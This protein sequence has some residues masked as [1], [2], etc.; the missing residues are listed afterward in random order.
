MKILVMSLPLH[1]NYGGFLQN[2][3]LCSY[4]K[5][6][7]HD[8]I[9][10]RWAESNC[11]ARLPNWRKPFVYLKRLIKKQ[12]LRYEKRISKEYAVVNKHFFDFQE[13]Y[14]PLSEEK[15]SNAKEL[16]D[17][18][19]K[20]KIEAVVIGSD[21][22]WRKAYPSKSI[23][24]KIIKTN[25]F[26][27]LFTYFA[28]FLPTDSNVKIL[29]YAASFGVD[30]MEY[31]EEE[32][33]KILPLLSRFDK[34]GVR[35]HSG[36]ILINAG[37]SWNLPVDSVIDPTML[38]EVERYK[39]MIESIGRFR[40]EKGIFSYVLDQSDAFPVIMDCVKTVLN[41]QQVNTVF[42]GSS[43]PNVPVEKRILP[44]VEIWLKNIAEAEFVVTDSFHGTVFSILFNKPFLV[45]GNV[46]RGN[47]RFESLLSLFG[48]ENRMLSSE[49]TV[50]SIVKTPIDWNRVND[51]LNTER[52]KSK[53]F[54]NIGLGV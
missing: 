12:E 16:L 27:S 41:I 4:L 45:V 8:V 6:S 40:F 48:L 15:F 54:F 18:I 52:E 11:G 14:I 31:S 49:N 1:N 30:Y 13:K 33:Q 46:G 17:F 35:E 43:D 9:S 26:P 44:S 10:C 53:K 37:Y 7:G 20:Y 42:L 2:F 28:D 51:I 22:V 38:L 47:A 25:V 32:K 3:A 36:K 50:E 39:K 29:S 21:Q 23:L 34:I 19:K 24:N 5:N